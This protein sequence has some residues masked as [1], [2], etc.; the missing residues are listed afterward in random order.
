M[1]QQSFVIFIPSGHGGQFTV[2]KAPP[3]LNTNVGGNLLKDM[4]AILTIYL[5]LL[6]FT[7][8]LSQ[9]IELI[10][11]GTTST[12][13][14]QYVEF[15]FLHKDIDTTSLTFIGTFKASGIGKKSYFENLYF[16]IELAAKKIG[17]NS[18]RVVDFKRT[19]E[20]D[21]SELT[22]ETYASNE[23]TIIQSNNLKDK[24]LIFIF[25]TERNTPNKRTTFKVNDEIQEISGG[26]YLSYKLNEGEEI[27]ISK[28]G[29]TG[30]AAWF[31]WKEDK[32]STYL[33]LTG[34]G[35]GPG[36]PAG[37]VGISFNTGRIYPM[38]KNL[39]ELLTL[40]LVD[41]ED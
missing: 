23:S 40:I 32:P 17:A 27:K 26:E 39:G 15:H 18:F 9:D 22:L 31:V 2:S 21:F 37:T 8:S 36:A 12:K 19:E 7:V 28:G 34:F 3:A 25:S 16:S 11:A 13:V 35:V 33:S 14:K 10:K 38:D 20:E 4:R 29:L 24:N 6:T 1:S 5:T 30:A 41:A